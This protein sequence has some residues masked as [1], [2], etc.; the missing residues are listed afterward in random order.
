MCYQ[1]E[2]LL[3]LNLLSLYF[4]YHFRQLLQ[5]CGISVESL[6]SS[7]SDQDE[8]SEAVVGQ[9]RVLL[10]CQLKSMLDIVEKDLLTWVTHF[11]LICRISNFL[12]YHIFSYFS[13]N[14]K[15]PLLG[16]TLWNECLLMST[17]SGYS[18]LSEHQNKLTINLC[19]SRYC[20][21]FLSLVISYCW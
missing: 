11:L 14:K 17:R 21:N 2:T 18:T 12:I 1:A 19:R 6:S 5:D 3:T 7:S 13:P 15:Y 16:F 4:I 20:Q 10:F 8:L 9:H